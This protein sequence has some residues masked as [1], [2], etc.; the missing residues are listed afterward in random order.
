MGDVKG[1]VILHQTVNEYD[2]ETGLIKKHVHGWKIGD[3]SFAL[4]KPDE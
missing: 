4:M 2:A 1:T 3:R